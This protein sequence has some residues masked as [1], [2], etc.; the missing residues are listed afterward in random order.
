MIRRDFLTWAGV[1]KP[2]KSR[3]D[4]EGFPHV[5]GVTKPS[6]SRNDSEG[7][8]HVAGVTKPSKSRNDSEGFPHETGVFRGDTAQRRGNHCN[9]VLLACIVTCTSLYILN[10]RCIKTSS[11]VNKSLIANI[12]ELPPR[13]YC[14]KR[15]VIVLLKDKRSVCL[16][17][18]GAFTQA[19]LRTIQ[20][21]KVIR[22][23]KMNKITADEELLIFN[24]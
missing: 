18:E 19:V 2:S 8:P 15:E 21:Q 6:K 17:P 9:I 14:N 16:D 11:F 3:N 5:A 1:T 10:C 4:S 13:P 12:K 23:F 22:A 7:F 20:R 24:K